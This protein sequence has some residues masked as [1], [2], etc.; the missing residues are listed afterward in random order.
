MPHLKR[1]QRMMKYS[2]GR[3]QWK[4]R[5]NTKQNAIDSGK[6]IREHHEM[7]G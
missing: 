4:E 6:V 1:M 3:I 5:S 2:Q 7:F